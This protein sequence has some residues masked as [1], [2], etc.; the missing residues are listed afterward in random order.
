MGTWNA[1]LFFDDTTCDV[2]EIYIELLKQ[3]LSNED[4]YIKICKEFEELFGTDEEALFWFALADTQWNLG[5]LLPEVK[6]KALKFISENNELSFRT[7]SSQRFDSWD[8]AL[9]KLKKKLE[10]PMMPEKKFKKPVEFVT[11]PWNVGDI[12]AYQFHTEFAKENDLYEKYI[13]FQ[14]IGDVEYFKDKIYSTI[15]IFDKIFTDIP[16]IEDVKNIRILPLST[17]PKDSGKSIEDYVPSFNWYM[18]ATMI[19]E[20]KIHYPKKHFIF[21]GNEKIP[22][23]RYKGNDF[24][25]FYWE[26]NR[27]EDWLIEYYLSWQNIQY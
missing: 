23:I 26:Q 2:K 9:Q 7:N 25:D 22:H 18:K 16:K 11:N 8:K 21:I 19:Y 10:S 1:G 17:S 4:A 12:Y 6:D 24:T 5:R 15:Q 13:L 27:M 3:Q 20:K 14:K